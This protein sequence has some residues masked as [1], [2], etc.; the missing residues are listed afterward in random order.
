MLKRNIAQSQTISRRYLIFFGIALVAVII[1]FDA[2]A[3]GLAL[4]SINR[5]FHA[6]LATLQWVISVYLLFGTAFQVFSGRLADI[7]GKKV[8]Y[9]F[10]V[11]LFIVASVICGVAP[12]AWAL[13][14]GRILQGIAFAFVLSLGM[15]IAASVFPKE[16]RG[17]VLGSYAMVVGLSQALGPTLGG[18]ILQYFGWRFLFYLN[19]PLGLSSLFLLSRF[20]F[21]PVAQAKGESIDWV[22][23]SLL[24][25]GLIL[26]ALMLNG[27]HDWIGHTVW[28]FSGVAL[29]IALLVCFFFFEKRQKHPLFDFSLYKDRNY[30]FVSIIRFI[31]LYVSFAIVFCLPLYLQNILGMPPIKAGGVIF[32]MTAGYALVSRISGKI[33]DRVG[34][35]RPVIFAMLL[36]VG[37]CIFMACLGLQLNWY[38]LIAGLLFL[39]L[40]NAIVLPGTVCMVMNNVPKEKVSVGVGAFYSVS[41]MGGVVGIALTGFAI[42]LFSYHKLSLGILKHGI[43]LSLL[44]LGMLKNAVG[45]AT[46]I[47]HTLQSFPTDQ[48]KILLP[49]AKSS[50]VFGFSIS[51]WVMVALSLFALA[52]SFFLQ[53]KVS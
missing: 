48:A 49:L 33:M 34:C 26:L 53:E 29:S 16:Q 41:L 19:V 13:I 36:G 1:N 18:V 47:S 3:T 30:F 50:F 51:M 21:E 38:V 9:L 4:A 2:T 43:N 6:K 46:S 45:G 27:M 5:T 32:I 8:V 42:G 24:S 40:S 52:L 20:Y 23:V 17:F 25:S 15:V 11:V 12:S 35:K 22:G 37:A 39:G 7:F 10:G 14:A 31:N 28:F 44:K